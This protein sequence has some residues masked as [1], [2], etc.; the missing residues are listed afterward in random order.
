MAEENSL[1]AVSLGSVDEIQL[2]FV[3]RD[4]SKCP[5]VW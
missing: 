4:K 3:C 2:G 1:Q 5:P